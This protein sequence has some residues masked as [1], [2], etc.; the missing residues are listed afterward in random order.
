MF[1]SSAKT[2]EDSDL[3][4]VPASVAQQLASIRKSHASLLDEYGQLKATLRIRDLEF[5]EAR[6]ELDKNKA[7]LEQTC[8]SVIRLQDMLARNEKDRALL[9]RNVTF[10][11]SLVV[12]ILL[13][14]L[15]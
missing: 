12:R 6:T 4:K 10:L 2:A 13:P 1:N 3:S 7:E 8:Q 15:Y 11:K 5:A 14:C 9:E